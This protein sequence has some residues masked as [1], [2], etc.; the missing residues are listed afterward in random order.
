M[1]L[2]LASLDRV[3]GA[4]H[5]AILQEVGAQCAIRHPD[6]LLHDRIAAIAVECLLR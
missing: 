5:E 6:S 2:T 1:M 4:S 3:T